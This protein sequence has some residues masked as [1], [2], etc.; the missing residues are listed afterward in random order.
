MISPNGCSYNCP[1]CGAT[2]SVGSPDWELDRRCPACGGA[3]EVRPPN[4]EVWKD[5][6]NDESWIGRYARLLP[7]RAD[8]IPAGSPSALEVIKAPSLAERLGVAELVLLPLSRNETGTFKD[9]EAGVIAAKVAEWSLDRV[10]VHSTGN[11]ARSYRHYIGNTG[12]SVAT[13]IPLSCADKMAGHVAMP[14]LP[15][16]AFNGPFPELSAV[17]KRV[18][19]HEDRLHLAPLHWKIEGKAVVAFVLAELFRDLTLIVQ[20][21]A[22]GY[23]LLGMEAGFARIDAAGLPLPRVRSYAL[24]QVDDADTLTFAINSGR[25]SLDSSELRLPVHPFEPT[26]QSTNPLATYKH[27]LRAMKSGGGSS[28]IE[29]VDRRVVEDEAEFFATACRDL[30]IPVD[31]EVEKSP[32]ISWAGLTCRAAAGLLR[33]RERIALLVTGGPRTL[34]EAPHFTSVLA[35]DVCN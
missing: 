34:I 25:S 22:G 14:R 27:V 20:T 26:L 6:T 7:T 28:S 4:A 35:R 19:E 3:L 30:G 23:G 32:F 15:M 24:F 21:V 33:D 5:V 18:A 16:Y 17:A 9:L 2:Y 11:T 29:S 13:F 1:R 12:A 10:S 8:S 31:F